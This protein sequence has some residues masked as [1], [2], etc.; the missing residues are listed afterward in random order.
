MYTENMAHFFF[1]NI[2]LMQTHSK[3]SG[4]ISC[5]RLVIMLFL[6]KI[7]NLLRFRDGLSGMVENDN[8]QF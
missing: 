8:R 5:S 7:I 3:S 1:D 4:S 6:T 2:S